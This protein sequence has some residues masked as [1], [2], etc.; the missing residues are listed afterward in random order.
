ML[1]VFLV[2]D[3]IV[4]RE[5][6]RQMIPWM[7]FGFELCGE[8]G[9]G[10][11]ALPLIQ[12]QKPDVVITDIRMPFMDGLELSRLVKKD[13]PETKI[14]IISGYHDFEYAKTA[15][16]IGVEQYL[17]K[18]V[19]RQEFLG[20]LK[21][22]RDCYDKENAQ[23]IYYEEFEK[24]MRQYEQH[25]RRDFFEKLVS[26][27]YSLN[28][29]YEQAA[30][31]RIDIMASAYN[32]VLFQIS[33]KEQQRL[34]TEYYSKTELKIWERIKSYIEEQE[35]YLLFRNHVFGYAVVVK[36]TPENIESLTEECVQY[37]KGYME[38]GKGK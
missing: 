16:S 9:D 13:L 35:E 4:V 31:Q 15:I 38:E 8:A 2:E 6:I 7:K 21:K 36:G 18:P 3:E 34:W 29:I 26:G 11:M 32:I 5:S 24:E 33:G 25:S 19:S 17:L 1:K 28:E 20:V 10:E 22:I 27:K 23:R 30:Q 12:R 14:V 37:L